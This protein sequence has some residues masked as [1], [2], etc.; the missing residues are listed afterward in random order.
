MSGQKL[1][2]THRIKSGILFFSFMPL[3]LYLIFCFSYSISIFSLES[4]KA[5]VFNFWP[6]FLSNMIALVLIFQLWLPALYMLLFLALLNCFYT[7]RFLIA[8]KNDLYIIFELF[9]L[10]MV[11]INGMY[12]YRDIMLSCYSKRL[13]TAGFFS[14]VLN[15]FHVQVKFSDKIVDGHLIDW[16]KRSI[17]V[18]L[19]HPIDLHSFFY[20]DEFCTVIFSFLGFHYQSIF[21][22]VQ[23]DSDGLEPGLYYDFEEEEKL[24][25]ESWRNY[26][27]FYKI[28]KLMG[29]VPEKIY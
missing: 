20:S 28:L 19:N 14:R 26:T 16:D 13:Q 17:R 12:L 18:R 27:Q 15:K 9:F 4:A 5:I 25:K 3:W 8:T 6:L 11:F 7:L 22:L 2:R 21:K 1:W 29:Y 24:P 10:L 23:F